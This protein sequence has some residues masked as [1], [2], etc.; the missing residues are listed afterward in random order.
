MN[1]QNHTN[2]NMCSFS[3]I[4]P[5][6]NKNPDNLIHLVSWLSG[7][8]WVDEIVVIN[9]TGTPLY[10]P[11]S[12]QKYINQITVPENLY[13]NPSWNLGMLNLK[14]KTDW[15]IFLND[16]IIVPTNVISALSVLPDLE[17]Y[18]LVGIDG[19]VITNRETSLNDWGLPPIENLQIT[20]TGNHRNWGFG[21]FVL[22]KRSEYITIPADLK[23]W[24]GDDYLFQ[25]YKDKGLKVGIA[26]IPITTNMSTTSDRPE[27]EE[28]RNKDL[29]TFNE[30]YKK[31]FIN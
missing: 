23:I 26:N 17:S 28:I 2:Q 18:S 10:L 5:T 12:G 16:D 8:F 21:V 25:E 14:R 27:F 9:N 4:I 29:Q 31:D 13:V 1:A 22:I 3:V 19:R 6:L 20:E 15:C 11:D 30:K 24:C 7:E